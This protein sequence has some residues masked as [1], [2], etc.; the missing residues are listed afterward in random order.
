MK[1]GILVVDD[2]PELLNVTLKILNPYYNVFSAVNGKQCMEVLESEKP[3]L[4][5][6]DVIL[7]DANGIELSKTIK[8]NP[9]FSSVY[10]ILLSSLKTSTES[11]SEGLENGADSYA[12]RPI[13]KRELLARVASAFRLID[14]EKERKK[15]SL[16]YESLFLSMQEGVYLHEMIYDESGNPT[17]YR[18]IEANP[19]SEK[20]LDIKVNDAIGKL[21]SELF[22]INEAP[23]LDIYAKVAESGLPASFEKYFPPMEKYFHISAFSQEK[24][25]FATVFTNITEKKLVEN[26]IIRNNLELQKLNAEKDKFFSIIAHDLKSPFNSIVGFSE[27]LVEES[28]NRNFEAIEEYAGIILKSSNQAMNLLMNLMEWAQS[29]TG[30]MQFIPEYIDLLKLSNDVISHLET[31]ARLK[32]I[33]I[34]ASS[35]ASSVVF[36]D[37]AM[38]STIIRNLITNALKFTNSGG[39]INIDL[40]KTKSETILTVSDTGV[41]IKKELLDKLFKINE[42]VS[43]QGTANEKGT[44]LG[45]VLCKEFME[46]HGGSISAESKVGIG[47]KIICSVPNTGNMG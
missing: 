36:A 13:N 6:L 34:S 18:I 14:A 44:G 26:K 29:Q 41:G 12:V 47:T 9:A 19:A 22:G 33:A 8:S 28:A 15:V 40:V 43:T 37:K 39:T 23:F 25:K 2:T 3:E 24:G 7:P 11:I 42:S 4:V 17:D 16:K 30:R 10:I 27:L 35:S 5:L 32:S 38:V 21:A 20:H 45:L 46:K 1:P 31:M